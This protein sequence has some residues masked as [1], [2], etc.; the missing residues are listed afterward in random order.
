MGLD[1]QILETLQSFCGVGGGDVSAYT[2][3]LK[4]KLRCGDQI[5][6]GGDPANPAYA[7]K[8][9]SGGV[10]PIYFDPAKPERSTLERGWK[11]EMPSAWVWMIISVF[12]LL[13]QDQIV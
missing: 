8:Y 6:F 9:V 11:G 12:L 3:Q 5:A 1:L 4:L 13:M 7:Q 10:V 2:R